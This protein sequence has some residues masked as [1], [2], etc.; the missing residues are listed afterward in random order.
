[1]KRIALLSLAFFLCTTGFSQATPVA[2]ESP[3]ASSSED[4]PHVLSE[5]VAH[6]PGV[7]IIAGVIDRGKIS[8]YSAGST[9]TST[10]LDEHTLF[11]IGSVTKTFT[12]TILATMVLAQIDFTRDAGGKINTLVLHQNGSSL[13]FVR[14][15]VAPPPATPWAT[16]AP[17]VSLDAATLEGYAGSYVV[18]PG[19]EF[20]VNARATS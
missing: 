14:A 5:R 4:L 16:A 7:G 19:A 6:E 8:I 2:T 13:T 1:M 12:A 17:T 11:E 3:S 10:A 9:G 18:G 15:G 20:I